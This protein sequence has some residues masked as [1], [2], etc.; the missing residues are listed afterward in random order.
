MRGEAAD[1]IHRKGG[2]VGGA[3]GEL[4]CEKKVEGGKERDREKRGKEGEREKMG[5][6]E[7]K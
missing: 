2:K 5:I 7:E 4:A 6:K 1:I 3:E